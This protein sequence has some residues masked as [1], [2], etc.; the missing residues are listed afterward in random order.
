A[1][2]FAAGLALG[3]TVGVTWQISSRR[4]WPRFAPL[5]LFAAIAVVLGWKNGLEVS[6]ASMLLFAA[7]MARFSPWRWM[8]IPLA[9]VALVACLPRLLD[10]DARLGMPLDWSPKYVGYLATGCIFVV[11]LASLVAGRCVPAEYFS[12]PTP[13]P[14][15][16]E[17]APPSR[18]APTEENLTPL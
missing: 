16:I 15:P 7:A 6:A 8:V 17:P 10:L 5:G 1:Q 18:A 11:C 3:A 4:G 14:P 12:P 2:G 13:D 9:G